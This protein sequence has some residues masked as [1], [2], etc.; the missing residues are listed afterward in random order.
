M[1]PDP[2]RISNADLYKYNSLSEIKLQ[3]TYRNLFKSSKYIGKRNK[4]GGI[5]VGCLLVK[6]FAESVAKH[7][8]LGENGNIF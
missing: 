7:N 1:Y 8:V 2:N 4:L 3:S 5:L 6:S